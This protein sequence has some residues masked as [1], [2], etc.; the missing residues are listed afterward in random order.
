MTLAIARVAAI[1]AERAAIEAK[2]NA[3]VELFLRFHATPAFRVIV[4]ATAEIH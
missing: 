1:P 3:A 4:I 2:K